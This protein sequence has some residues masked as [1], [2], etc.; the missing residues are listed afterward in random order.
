MFKRAARS[1]QCRYTAIAVMAAARARRRMVT[2]SAPLSI[3]TSARTTARLRA[4][5]T[6][7]LQEGLLFQWS[8]L[9]CF[10]A[11]LYGLQMGICLITTLLLSV[12]L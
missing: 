2:G 6:G 5:L 10:R 9:R 12:S 8:F 4:W 7:P 3:E 1:G 11:L